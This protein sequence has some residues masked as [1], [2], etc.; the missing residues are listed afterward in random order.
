MSA[1]M[2]GG[3]AGAARSPGVRAPL[4]AA[5]LL[6]IAVAYFAL[7][8]P[9]GLELA[10][11]GM[12][13]LPSR[14]VLQG[15]V[16]YRDFIHLYGPSLFYLNG[17]L[18]Q[19]AG[20]ELYGLRWAVLGVKVLAV[21]AVYL[22]ARRLAPAAAALAAALLTVAI[23]GAPWWLFSTP[24]ANHYALTLS[25]AGL[26][27]SLALPASLLVRCAAA[28][29]CFGLAATFKQTSGLFGLLALAVSLLLAGAEPA[30]APAMLAGPAGRAVRWL[31]IA[32]TGALLA[33]YVAP[34]NDGWTLAVVAAPAAALLALA[35]WREWRDVLPA[36]ERAAGA[37]AIV[38]AGLAAA[39]PVAAYG[40][41]FAARGALAAFVHDSI[42]GLPQRMQWF[43]PYFRPPWPAWVAAAGSVA[44]VAAARRGGGAAWGVVALAAA[45]VLGVLLRGA[46]D[47][48]AIWIGALALLL[49]AIAWGGLLA[50]A[51]QPA[52]PA[53][54]VRFASFAAVS[55]LFLYP[56]GDVWHIAMAAPAFLPLA[57]GLAA[58]GTPRR[59]GAA[60][61]A[62]VLLALLLASPFVR[63]L[64][65]TVAAGAATPA[66]GPLRGIADAP[67]YGPAVRTVTDALRQ[68]PAGA[69]MLV[70]TAESLFYLLAQRDSALPAGE[71]IIY[72]ISFRLI[73]DDD[74]RALLPERE[75]VEALRGAHPTLVE[76]AATRERFRRVYPRAAAMIDAHYRVAVDAPP[77]RVL[78]WTS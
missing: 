28:G 22:C 48:S 54:L 72:L 52:A 67:P 34:R 56:S 77:F 39:V 6:L 20:L 46:A 73:T 27:L 68:R 25:L 74:A 30:A 50:L 61:G 62:A 18:L 40:A 21:A 75:V 65:A 26:W 11:T 53:A 41:F 13:L 55:L 23:W 19:A 63:T 4:Y 17:A 7:S 24:Y 15:A 51:R 47:W 64:A 10:D 37:A 36:G 2:H 58:G 42:S 78:E 60:S 5:A 35:G 12:I 29:L 32:V 43:D 31:T 44:G 38:V 49:P 71:F 59:R 33:A 70:T 9:F 57:A 14:R 8:L 16:P 76:N 45:A 66:S 3:S 69:P 1:A